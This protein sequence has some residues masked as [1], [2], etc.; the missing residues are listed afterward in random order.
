[1]RLKEWNDLPEIMKNPEVKPY[2]DSLKEKTASLIGKRVFDLFVS[3]LMIVIL[4]PL[5]LITAVAIEIDSRGP[6]FYRQARITQYGREFRIFK[7]RSMIVDADKKGAFL[8][9]NNDNRITRVG[10]I[11]RKTKLDEIPQLFNI[12]SGDMTFVGTRPEVKKYVDEYTPEMLA[13]LL[14]PAGITSL[15]SIYY[16]DENS[17]IDKEEDADRVYLERILPDKM[18]WNLRGLLSYSFWGDVKLMFMTFFAAMGK[19]YGN[20]ERNESIVH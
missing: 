9:V 15:A 18:K 12:V 8:T 10:K 13:T 14:L 6:V 5:I 4:T 3:V 19:E 20:T 7:F 11:L 2:Y 1:M 17:L 16:K